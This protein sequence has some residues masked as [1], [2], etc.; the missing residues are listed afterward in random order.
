MRFRADMS[1]P[2]TFTALISSL[3]PLAKVATLKLKSDTVHLICF[4]SV[5]NGGIQV[6]SQIAV[7]S[8]FV[9]ETFRLESNSNN[10]IYL[11][12]S[13]EALQRAL[14]S[15]QGAT[16]VTIKL[17]KKGGLGPNGTGKGARPVLSLSVG[18]IS[19]G[20]RSVSITHDVSVVVKKQSEVDAMKEP[21]CPAPDVNIL[22]PP[23]QNLKT[24][25]ERLKT[26]APT[27]T[28]SANFR[29]EFRLKASSDEAKVETEWRE[30]KHPHTF[31]EQEADEDEPRDPLEF[32]SVTVDARGLL[33]FL[34]SYSIATTTI[35]CICANHCAIFY[36]YIGDPKDVGNNGGVLTFFVPAVNEDGDD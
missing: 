19:K 7:A 23:L 36:V 25:C 18:N 28:I 5:G 3:T 11:E 30:L 16:E 8:I 26:I 10:E 33:K 15:A 34:A 2:S 22:L 4:E 14:R 31:E 21:L 9:L 6:W 12:V 27:I 24:V 1:S 17:A 32:H 20:G 29:G 13:T 35:A